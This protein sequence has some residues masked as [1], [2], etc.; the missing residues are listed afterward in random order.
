VLFR[1]RP[2]DAR[3]NAFRA[4][5]ADV[6][7]AG[8]LFAPH[9]AAPIVRM[10]SSATMMRKAARHD[11][12]AVSQL[13]PGENFA[14]L[15]LS[16]GW[17]W[18]YSLHDHYVGYV[19]TDLIGDAV[20]ASHRVTARLALLFADPSIKAPA[21]GTLP[22]GARISGVMAGDFLQTAQ[23]Y[24]HH[25]HVAPIGEPASDPVAVAEGFVG[26]PYLWGGRGADGIDCSG[27]VQVALAAC[28]IAAPRDTDLQRDALGSPLP[29]DAQL[30]RGDI[31]SFPGHVGLMVDETNLLH[32]NAHW[33]S[34]VVEP[35]ADVVARLEPHH[36]RPILGRRR[37]S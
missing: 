32:A 6:A 35:L 31:I 10:A 20:E 11:A 16:G 36:D 28:G 30:R 19:A 25:R 29:G 37:L 2:L 3:V 34:V 14:I 26:M 4:D 15:D 22:F 24:L 12:E 13:L 9:Y 7:L 5:I 18:G 23:G 33:M 8:T 17:A 21:I 27:L 1:S